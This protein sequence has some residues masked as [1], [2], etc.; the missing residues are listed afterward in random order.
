[1]LIILSV[2]RDA[3]QVSLS[4]TACEN[5]KGYSHSEKVWQFLKNLNTELPSDYTVTSLGIY[6]TGMK[7]YVH[8]KPVDKCS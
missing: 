7:I 2:D 1:M 6:P 4:H 8:R 5:I 3:E